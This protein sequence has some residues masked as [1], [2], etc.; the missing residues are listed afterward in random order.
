MGEEM[1]LSQT[2]R[3]LPTLGIPCKVLPVRLYCMLLYMYIT[4]YVYYCICIL[5]Y[6]YIT[7]YYWWLTFRSSPFALRYLTLG[8]H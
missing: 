1:P 2:H 8:A 4:V 7:V 6:M 3:S 5:L